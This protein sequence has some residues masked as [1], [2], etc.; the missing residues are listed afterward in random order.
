LK[1]TQRGHACW[2]K[3][4]IMS[5]PET[6]LSSEGICNGWCVG[7]FL[8]LCQNTNGNVKD[9]PPQQPSTTLEEGLTALSQLFPSLHGL[10]PTST[11]PVVYALSMY[12]L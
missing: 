7:R 1:M 10:T 12:H 2:F 9:L 5:Q 4:G 3:D 11:N 6:P 8:E